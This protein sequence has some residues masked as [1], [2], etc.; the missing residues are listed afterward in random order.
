MPTD[1]T[2][3]PDPG[4]AP[5]GRTP[6]TNLIAEDSDDFRLMMRMFLETRG[7]EVI[8]AGDGAGAVE[9][10]VRHRPAVVLMDL[11]LP[12]VDGIA[13]AREVRKE[14]TPAETAIVIVTAYDTAEFRAE[15]LDAGCAGYVVKPVDPSTLLEVIE[16]LLGHEDY[17]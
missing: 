4:A 6:R 1:S 8:T 15:A 9:A 5:A 7:Y 3:P 12:V 10:A 16:L 2:C 14:L 13:A 11:G 17:S